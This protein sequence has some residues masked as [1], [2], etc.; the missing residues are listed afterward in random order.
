[1]A[2]V[3]WLVTSVCIISQVSLDLQLA[4]LGPL[5]LRVFTHKNQGDL[6]NKTICDGNS[7]SSPPPTSVL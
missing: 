2:K 3:K 6:C 4:I 7:F 1:M 5:A